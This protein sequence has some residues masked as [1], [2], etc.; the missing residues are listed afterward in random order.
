MPHFIMDRYKV[1]V[2]KIVCVVSDNGDGVCDFYLKPQGSISSDGSDTVIPDGED[3]LAFSMMLGIAIGERTIGDPRTLMRSILGMGVMIDHH[4]TKDNRTEMLKH[5]RDPVISGRDGFCTISEFLPM[6]K[7][8]DPYG[9]EAYLQVNEEEKLE[10]ST[11]DMITTIEDALGSIG[12][13]ITLFPGDLV[14]IWLDGIDRP[15]FPGDLI[16]GGI[17]GL[18]TITARIVE[19]EAGPPNP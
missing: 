9:L 4:L 5:L 18:S 11:R 13:H 17:S 15:S 14:G 7:I 16:E 12:R 1:D 8:G 19:K 10:M 6:K 2:G 3:R